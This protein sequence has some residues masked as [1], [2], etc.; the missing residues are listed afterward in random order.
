MLS[1]AADE[2]QNPMVGE[3]TKSFGHAPERT[4]QVASEGASFGQ[5]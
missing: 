2:S 4:H 5:L 3:I 1:L